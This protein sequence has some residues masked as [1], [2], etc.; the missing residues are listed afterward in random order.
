MGA[1]SETLLAQVR[2]V[3]HG[4]KRL[5]LLARLLVDGVKAGDQVDGHA[6][7]LLAQSSALPER[8][9]SRLFV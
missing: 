9:K 1:V 5:V 3:F 7:S 4:F 8:R 6:D 2:Q